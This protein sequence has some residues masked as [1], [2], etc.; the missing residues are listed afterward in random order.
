M[1]MRKEL[2]AAQ[3][4]LA[5]IARQAVLYV[6][7]EISF[8]L[9]K[10]S[11]KELREFFKFT[12]EALLD[13]V[14]GET[15]EKMRKTIRKYQDF[16][17]D[18]RIDERLRLLTTIKRVLFEFLRTQNGY[19]SPT[20][21]KIDE[22]I[23]ENIL[24]VSYD[25][26]I[27]Q[28][29]SVTKDEEEAD[30]IADELYKT[31]KRL[32][33]QANFI[34]S[35]LENSPD[36]TATLD[37]KRKVILWND[38]AK[39]LTGYP[40][41]RII[42][43]VL[44]KIAAEDSD[45]RVV[46]REA[47]KKGKVYGSELNIKTQDDRIIPVSVSVSTI[48][49]A[50]DKEANFVVV[51]RDASELRS[52]RDRIIDAEK[53][54]AMAKIAGAV[55]H[56]V[57]N[58]LNSMIL[59]LDLLEDELSEKNVSTERTQGQLAIFRE[60]IEKLNE[61]VTN[62]LSLSRLSKIDLK[63]SKAQDLVT[64]AIQKMKATHEKILFKKNFDA[65]D[66]FIAIDEKQFSRVLTNLFQNSIEA[67]NPTGSGRREI[68]IAIFKEGHNVEIEIEDAGD[69][70][71]EENLEKLFTPFYSTKSGGTGLGLYIVREIVLAH[72]GDIEIKNRTGKT[73]AA[74][75][76]SLPMATKSASEAVEADAVIRT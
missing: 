13:D 17:F 20:A 60:E 54:S 24:E 23:D 40:P 21:M 46:L 42:G 68:D 56:E 5:E 70:I 10:F 53:L 76:I 26:E 59:N 25:Y 52:M 48:D 34:N 22:L 49:N 75:R 71:T 30:G 19:T 11:E 55:A 32:E 64:A 63:V 18:M 41:T 58:P 27:E 43:K 31:R 45:F 73:G 7:D 74:V 61:I 3:A 1:L 39:D 67:M 72:H 8:N 16:L 33:R 15:H 29:K 9:E 69:G 44:E 50:G 4:G 62:Y 2:I 14:A 65:E 36:A 28:M 66:L 57:R 35:L 6:K 51:M 47:E 38:A 12:I 37:A